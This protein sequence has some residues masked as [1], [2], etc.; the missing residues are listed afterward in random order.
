MKYIFL[1]LVIVLNQQTQEKKIEAL[2]KDAALWQVGE[3][4]EKVKKAREELIKIG[5]PSLEYICEKK[6]NT[7]KT[8]ELR[9][10]EAVAKG[11]K[12]EA[13]PLLLDKLN[14]ENDTV[15]KNVAWV[16]GKIEAK[17]AA[18]KLIHAL[19]IEKNHKVE[20]RMIE[21]LGRIGD[22]TATPHI[23]PYL[24]DKHE[25]LK[26]KAAEAIGKLNDKRGVEPLIKSLDDEFF[27]VRGTSSWALGEIGDKG[28][29]E[30]LYV[31][32]NVKGDTTLLI[33]LV[34]VLGKIGETIKESDISRLN[35]IKRAVLSYLDSNNWVL[36]GHTIETLSKIKSEGIVTI[37]K[38][39]YEIETHPFVLRKYEEALKGE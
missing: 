24:E 11:L 7:D 9:A 15:R 36:R 35:S 29:S 39:K 23:I 5:K 33:N 14:S 21:A 6:L 20:A 8:L 34:D 2:F 37:L 12:D 3:N 31:L 32:N 10:I 1:I 4:I 25:L 19:N 22:T 38:A 30:I 28:L 13:I 16:L 18:P 17:N 26:I 27:T